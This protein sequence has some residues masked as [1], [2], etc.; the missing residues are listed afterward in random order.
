MSIIRTVEVQRICTKRQMHWKH[1]FG[2]SPH[3]PCWKPREAVQAKPYSLIAKGAKPEPFY[4]FSKPSI[5]AHSTPAP[6]TSIFQQ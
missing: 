2:R 6:L 3:S 4:L 5:S 1:I